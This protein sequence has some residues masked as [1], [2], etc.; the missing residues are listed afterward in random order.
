MT[1]VLKHHGK[2]QV[3][4]YLSSRRIQGP[5]YSSTGEGRGSGALEQQED[6]GSRILKHWGG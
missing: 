2:V 1:G 3:L 6:T 4:E 5:K